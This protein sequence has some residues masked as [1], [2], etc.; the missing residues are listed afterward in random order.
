MKCIEY[1][2]C[3]HLTMKASF[4]TQYGY[5]HYKL[6]AFIC[7]LNMS[8]FTVDNLKWNQMLNLTCTC[9]KEFRWIVVS[10]LGF[11]IKLTTGTKQQ[12]SWNHDHQP[13]VFSHIG[14][15]EI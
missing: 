12:S 3:Q 10:W 9:V 15:A 6:N 2:S 11:K 1:N 7:L 13:S 8:K 5:G 14:I 4:G